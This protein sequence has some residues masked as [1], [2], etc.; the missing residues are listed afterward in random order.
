[1]VPLLMMMMMMMLALQLRL[2]VVVERVMDHCST[3]VKYIVVGFFTPLLRCVDTLIIVLCAFI[4]V[5]H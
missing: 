2:A 4:D 1:M 3:S 5:V